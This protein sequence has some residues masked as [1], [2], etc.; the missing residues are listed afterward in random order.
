MFLAKIFGFVFSLKQEFLMDT[1]T[2]WSP[3]ERTELSWIE[4]FDSSLMGGFFAL[5]LFFCCIE[6]TRVMAELWES[7]K[8]HVSYFKNCPLPVAYQSLQSINALWDLHKCIFSRCIV[9]DIRTLSISLKDQGLG[10]GGGEYLAKCMVSHLLFTM[11]F[12]SC[13][14]FSLVY[15]FLN[16]CHFRL[17]SLK[18]PK[19]G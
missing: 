14:T 5:P 17:Y 3:R 19:L 9:E 10:W 2:F 16:N 15:E 1:W 7:D 8:L 12:L 18:T 13:I 11:T 4:C 6:P